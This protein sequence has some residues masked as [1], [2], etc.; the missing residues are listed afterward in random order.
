[1]QNAIV[2]W[3]GVIVDG[4]NRYDLCKKHGI[5]IITQAMRFED[6]KEAMIW[7]IDNQ[8]G[9]RDLEP[10]ER[11]ELEFKRQDLHESRQ[12]IR[13]DLESVKDSLRTSV[14]HGTEV[15]DEHKHPSHQ[16]AEDADVSPRTYARAK[17]ID[18]N[19]PEETKQE[20][21]EGTLTINRAYLD[22]KSEEKASEAEDIGFPIDK[23]LGVLTQMIGI[24]LLWIRRNTRKQ[25]TKGDDYGKQ[26]KQG[27]VN[28]GYRNM[29]VYPK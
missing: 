2:T 13:R 4:H 16:S 7:M 25:V 19:A 21:R 11:C 3:N 28:L 12:G 14:P 1:M 22:L 6:K 20:L 8:K 17:F 29:G 9:R 26:R 23:R 18:V 24:A 10:Y 15:Q 5:P 27:P